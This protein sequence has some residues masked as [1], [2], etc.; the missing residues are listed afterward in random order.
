MFLLTIH[1][2]MKS[3]SNIHFCFNRHW[4]DFYK[5]LVNW[6]PLFA[7]MDKEALC[8]FTFSLRYNFGIVF[9][10]I[11]DFDAQKVWWLGQSIHNN[12]F[13]VVLSLTI[14]NPY[15]IV[16]VN[17]LLFTCRNIYIFRQ[18]TWS[19]MLHFYMYAIRT[20]GSRIR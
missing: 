12:T 7:I 17:I 15:N 20:L 8:S 4:M 9:R 13:W 10:L 2:V 3:N 1:L 11:S 18:T 19:L 16:H 14:R 6:V 5:W